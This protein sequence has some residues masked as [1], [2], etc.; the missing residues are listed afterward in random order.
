MDLIE[1]IDHYQFVLIN[2]GREEAQTLLE[3]IGAHIEVQK[4]IIDCFDDNGM[5]SQD[6][7]WSL[8]KILKR[9]KE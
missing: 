4:A 3:H 8:N 7:L 5:C 2:R 9:L 6:T 1:L